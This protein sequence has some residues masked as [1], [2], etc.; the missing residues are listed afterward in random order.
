MEELSLDNILTES[1]IENLFT[2][3]ET[4]ESGPESSEVQSEKKETKENNKENT[5]EIN[6]DNLFIGESESVDSEDNKDLENNTPS[7]GQSDISPNTFSSL[8]KALADEGVFQ[9]L[10]EESLKNVK[11]ASS[12]KE[13]ME[14]YISSN[15][16]ERY[17]KI[18]AALNMNVEPSQISKYEHTL[19]S[20]SQISKEALEDEGEQGERLRK[21]LIYQDFINRGF[22][23]DRAR[24]EVEKSFDSGSD[25][26]DASEALQSNYVFYKNQYDQLLQQAQASQDAFIKQREEQAEQLRNSILNDKELFAGISPDKV[27]RKKI[28][29]N[30]SKPVYS[31]KKTGQT[32]TAIQ[33]YERENRLDFLKYVSLFF[34]MTNGFK[35]MDNLIKDRVKK[36]KNKGLSELERVINNTSRN[37]DGSLNF[38]S[39]VDD[40]KS[41]FGKGWKLD[42]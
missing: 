15:I 3:N 14:N 37:S 21:S 13:M 35:D 7:S 24:K 31:D 8:A 18:D 29:E 30:I 23:Q 20:L 2:N 39:G 6:P 38:A 16:D 42:V 22:S 33:K 25:I 26:E 28:Y 11:D 19:N 40:S 27:T 4:Q 17:K 1:E 32:L 10:D 36:E 5:V 9:N 34:T 41:Y 12:F